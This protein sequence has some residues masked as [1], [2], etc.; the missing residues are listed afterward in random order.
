MSGGIGFDPSREW[1]GIDAVDLADP[2]RVLGLA[3][4]VSDPAVVTAA[5]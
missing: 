1:L 3:A 4:N 5:A 2:F